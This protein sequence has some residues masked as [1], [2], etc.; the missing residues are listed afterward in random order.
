MSLR[1]CCTIITPC[2][3]TKDAPV[4]GSNTLCLH[5]ELLMQVFMLPPNGNL[6]RQVL[7]D[8]LICLIDL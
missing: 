3:V 7:T 4:I 5:S 8:V 6:R 2:L 1:A